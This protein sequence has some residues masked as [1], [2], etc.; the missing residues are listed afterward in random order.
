MEGT[1]PILVEVQ[2]LTS[3]A[4]YG[5][6]QRNVTGF[7]LRRLSML[8]AVLEKRV[9]V[10][11]GASDVFVNVVGGMRIDEPA[12]DMAVLAAVASSKKDRPIPAD[13]VMMGEVGLAGELRSIAGIESRLKEA[14]RLGF[15]RAVVPRKGAKKLSGI[16]QINCS[17]AAEAFD[18]IF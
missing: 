10:P 17:T 3:N 14:K 8:T 7:D 18:A 1:R 15:K 4:S 11:I 2:A 16:V 6:P 9:G 5:T 13:I 12:A